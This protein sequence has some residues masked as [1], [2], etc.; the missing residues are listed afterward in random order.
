M[1]GF[2]RWRGGLWLVAVLALAACGPSVTV[3]NSTTLPVRVVITGPNGAETF[4][5][6]PHESSTTDVGEGHYT[7]VVVPDADW[8]PYAQQTRDFLNQQLANSQN[9]TGPQLLD[10]VQ[11]L[12]DIAARMAQMQSAAGHSA[13][14]SGNVTGDNSAVATISVGITDTLTLSCR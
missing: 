13:S 11:R 7:V 1:K 4:A 9:L 6:S 8:L 10:L 5:P 3:Q 14:C 2:K 12:K